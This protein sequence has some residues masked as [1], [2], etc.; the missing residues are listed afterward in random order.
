MQTTFHVDA[1]DNGLTFVPCS[2]VWQDICC[3]KGNIHHIGI[4]SYVKHS[5]LLYN[6][7]TLYIR[8]LLI[9]IGL[10]VGAYL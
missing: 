1:R 2:H 8:A 3:P 5:E 10:G 7:D 4:S 9:V 6:I